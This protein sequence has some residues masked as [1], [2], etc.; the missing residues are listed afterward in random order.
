[1]GDIDEAERDRRLFAHPVCQLGHGQA[2]AGELGDDEP[3]RLAHR[4]AFIFV[5]A[6]VDQ[7]QPAQVIPLIGEHDPALGIRP[8]LDHAFEAQLGQLPREAVARDEMVPA[9]AQEQRQVR[10]QRQDVLRRGLPTRILR[11]ASPG[12]S[13]ASVSPS[14][15]ALFRS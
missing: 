7:G 12:S 9:A 10:R 14:Q 15:T 6:P 2:Q 11:I 8:L 4:A 1:M 5:T 13:G 3:R